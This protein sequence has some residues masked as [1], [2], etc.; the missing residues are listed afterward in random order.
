MDVHVV[1]GHFAHVVQAGK[2]H[3][4]DPQRDDV[5]AGD[6]HVGRIIILQLRRGLGPAQSRVRPRAELNQVSSTSGSR[7]SLWPG[8]RVLGQIGFLAAQISHCSVLL[9]ALPNHVAA[10]GKRLLQL[11]LAS[12]SCS[13]RSGSGV[14]T[15]AGG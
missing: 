6:E 11:F 1:E 7:V 10:A 15:R 12:P 3:P 13:T 14:P 5:A 4:G 9:V 8:D 2:H